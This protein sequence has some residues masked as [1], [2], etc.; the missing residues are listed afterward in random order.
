M[1]DA[2]AWS[3]FWAANAGA[4]QGGCLPRRWADIEEAQAAVWRDFIAALPEGA[5]VLDLATGDGRVLG[6]MRAARG[7]LALT[8][9]DLAPEL[10]APPAGTTTR[11]GI[12][13]ESLPFGDG[14]FAAVVSQ[15][16]FEYGDVTKVAAEI[17]RVLAPGG[18]IGLMVHRGDGPIL[19]HNLARRAAI[20]WVLE[21][22]KL[23]AILRQA[24]D[25]PNGGPDVAAQVAAAIGL[26]GA[27][28]FGEDS[29]GWEI[30][31]ALRRAVLMGAQAG[32]EAI[33]GTLAEIEARAA[34][35][36]GRIASLERAC[37]VADQREALAAAFAAQGLSLQA[38]S[39][40]C[41][42]SGRALASF[43]TFS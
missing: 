4:P 20:D 2:A 35:E 33:L 9:I 38:T 24:L 29:P 41:E 39:D 7:D 34:N 6:W 42:P 15:F 11:G 32:R 26:V 25:A 5:E 40:V 13:M 28:R 8:G 37:G 23:G 18:R 1:N 17:A 36:V 19:A 30:P 27:N 3:D 43:L 22:Q 10:P 21:D 31:E 12:A 16:G 14:T